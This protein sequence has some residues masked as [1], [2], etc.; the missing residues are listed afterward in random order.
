MDPKQIGMIAVAVALIAVAVVVVMKSM[1]GSEG[2]ETFWVCDSCGEKAQQGIANTSADC[3][4]CSEGQLVQ[5][6][7][8]RCKKC[9]SAFEGYHLNFSPLAERASDVAKEAGP[10]PPGVMDHDLQ[11]IREPGGKWL[12]RNAAAGS[13]IASDLTCP[14]CGKL[15]RDQFEMVTDPAKLKE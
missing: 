5:R 7:H 12:W 4:K 8:F 1:G 3:P 6:V 13:K 10:R 11:L 14:K 2:T 15:K 9:K